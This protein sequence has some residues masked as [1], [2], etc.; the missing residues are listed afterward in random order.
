[1][2]PYRLQ[3]NQLI[4]IVS[5][6]SF[7]YETHWADRTIIC[8]AEAGLECQLCNRQMSKTRVAVLLVTADATDSPRFHEFSQD[9]WQQ[10]QLTIGDSPQVDWVLRITKPGKGQA[11]QIV[12]ATKKPKQRAYYGNQALLQTIAY[13][14]GLRVTKP[15]TLEELFHTNA[16]IIGYRSSVQ[17]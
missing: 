14:H 3:P 17:A 6:T 2:P 4:R 1:M 16:G 13:F 15:T 8:G 7:A 9:L 5:Q 12:E 10:I 11:A